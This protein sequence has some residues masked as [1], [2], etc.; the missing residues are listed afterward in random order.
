MSD[1]PR[2]SFLWGRAVLRPLAALGVVVALMPGAAEA[3]VNP[4]VSP[5]CESDAGDILRLYQSYFGRIPDVAGA[6]YWLSLNAAGVSVQNIRYWFGQSIEF[7]SKYGAMSHSDFVHAVYYNVLDRP[8]DPGGYAYWLDQM[9][10]G[11]SKVDVIYWVSQSVEFINKYPYA[12]SPFCTFTTYSGY[13]RDEVA[14]GVVH[15]VSPDG[16]V[17]V[18]YIH[19]DQPGAHLRVSPG[20]T[21]RKP[22]YYGGAV[23]INANWFSGS[24]VYGTSRSSG[25]NAPEVS[26]TDHRHT[27]IGFTNTGEVEMGNLYRDAQSAIPAH[28]TDAVTGK[29]LVYNG[30]VSPWMN[31]GDPTFIKRDPRTAAG[32]DASGNVLILVTVDGRNYGPGMTGVETANLMLALGATEAVMLDGGGSSAMS[33]NTAIVNDPSDGY[34]R[35]VA[36]QLIFDNGT[37]VQ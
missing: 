10:N 9:N 28:V 6:N 12:Q 2:N 16:N 35:A 23:A 22:G 33:V 32:L 36:N 1:C 20:T 26:I 37:W 18:A 24:S 25:V 21:H 34:P 8:A 30:A 31:G 4:A 15:A 11:L 17:N 3:A 13:A 7:Q 19:L 5:S 29:E 14:P 27:W